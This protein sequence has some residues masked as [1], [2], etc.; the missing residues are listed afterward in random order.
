MTFFV[1]LDLQKHSVF[2]PIVYFPHSLFYQFNRK[3]F[4][5]L[6]FPVQYYFCP[7]E[8]DIS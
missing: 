3:F 2:I 8:T 7:L 1:K 6:Y 5:K 4:V